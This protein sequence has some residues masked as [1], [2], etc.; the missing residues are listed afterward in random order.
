MIGFVG[1]EVLE[2]PP[3]LDDELDQP[4]PQLGVI[5][6]KLSRTGVDVAGDAIEIAGLSLAAQW[7]LSKLSNPG[8]VLHPAKVLL[9]TVVIVGL[10][11]TFRSIKKFLLF[12]C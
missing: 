6:D 1:V 2:L 7:T 11:A 3:Q 12:L 5:L 8:K 4:P 10:F 9:H